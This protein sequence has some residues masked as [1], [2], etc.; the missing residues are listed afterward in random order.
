MSKNIS[1]GAQAAP[2]EVPAANVVIIGHELISK[3]LFDLVMHVLVVNQVVDYENCINKI[4]FRSD[5]PEGKFGR[6]D[7]ETADITINLQNHFDDAVM[8]VKEEGL[9]YL[10]LRSHLWFGLMTTVLHE[11]LHAMAYK[12]DPET[13]MNDNRESVEESIAEEVDSCIRT[14]IR[15]YDVEPASMEDE[16]F[17]GTRYMEFWVKYI[18]E[19]SEQWAINQNVVHK[20]GFIWKHGEA[21][22]DTF[23]EWYRSAYNLEGDTDWDKDVEPLERFGGVERDDLEVE[24]PKIMPADPSKAEVPNWVKPAPVA[25]PIEAPAPEAKVA[26]ELP[27]GLDSETLALLHMDE[28]P[29]EVNT[30]RAVLLEMEPVPPET[31]QP[32]PEVK[33]PALAPVQQELPMAQPVQNAACRSC[34]KMLVED[35]KFCAHCGTSL[36]ATAMPTLPSAPAVESSSTQPLGIVPHTP[37]FSSGAKRPMRHDLPNHNL[38]PEQIRACVGEV[39]IRCYQHIF[40][41]CGWS[42][43]QNPSFAPELRNAVAEPISVVGIPCIDQ[44]LVGMDSNDPLSGAFTFCAPAVEGMIRGKVTKDDKNIPGYTLYFNFNG[45]EVKRLIYPQ[46]QWKIDPKNPSAYSG[47]AQRAQQGAMIVWL[48]NAVRTDPG[49]PWK[50]K[51]ENGDLQWMV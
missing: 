51:I 30:E 9:S 36:E 33:S 37:Q 48:L 32:A 38:T 4:I 40:S 12:I 49:K 11:I 6:F 29:L 35:A 19:N 25:E 42:P 31:H 2:I 34:Q 28:E 16:P 47:P 20:E 17:F 23:K 24:E 21:S 1:V 27:A 50:A 3:K 5:E 15:D 39:F 26:T 7:I 44:V 18:K 8:S 45:H 41:K 22:C 43:S 46:N 10:S 13:M 14:L